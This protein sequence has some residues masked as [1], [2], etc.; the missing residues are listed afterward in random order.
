SSIAVYS[1]LKERI[2]NLKIEDLIEIV[3]EYFKLKTSKKQSS[4]IG[5][6]YQN[7]VEKLF[8]KKM[9]FRVFH[10]W[11]GEA[12]TEVVGR[13]WCNLEY[14]MLKSVVPEHKKFSEMTESVL[15]C[16]KDP[17]FPFVDIM[18][19]SGKDLF[20]VQ[21]SISYSHAKEVETF[22][23]KWLQEKMDLSLEE[24][25]SSGGKVHLFY[26]LP[27]R[28]ANSLLKKPV[29][30]SFAWKGATAEDKMAQVEEW[31]SFL[32]CGM[33]QFEPNL[34]GGNKERVLYD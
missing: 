22:A 12:T 14:P 26:A 27:P 24:L 15:Y 21:I 8:H 11:P 25:K 2:E 7:L 20:A 23:E 29:P 19:R 33:I 16:P 28:Q 30:K 1:K 10:F 6:A 17:R 4:E 9:K 32:T 34:W 3:A 31:R 18:W 5:Y 13:I